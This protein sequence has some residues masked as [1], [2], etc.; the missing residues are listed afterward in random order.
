MHRKKWLLFCVLILSLST[1]SSAWAAS[2]Y[3]FTDSVGKWWEQS[4]AECSAAGLVGGRSSGKFDPKA[5]VSRGEAILF[6]VRALGQRAEADNYNISAGNYN[7]PAGFPEIY[8]RSVA[9]AADKGY[10]SKAGIPSMQPKQPANRA[11]VAVLFANALKLSADGYQLNF[12]DNSAIPSSLQGYVA[13][14]VKH[15]IMS[16]RTGNKFEPNANVTRAEM[17]AIICRLVES[18]KIAPYPDKQFVAKLTAVDAVGRKITVTKGGQTLSYSLQTDALIYKDGTRI[19]LSSFKVNDSAKIVLDSTN[20]VVFMAYSIV[21]PTSGSVGTGNNV[22]I[23]TTYT[24]TIKGL[25]TGSLSF[26]PDSSAINAYPLAGSLK[27]TQGGLT[28][29]LTALTSGARAEIKVTGGSVTEVNLISSLPTGTEKKGYIVNMYL[30]YFTVRYDN[31]TS[32]QIEKNLVTGTFLQYARGQ[33]VALYKSGNFITSI[34][35]LNEASKLFGDIVNVNSSAIAIEDLDD[36][37]RSI[38]LASS[39]RVKDEDGDSMDLDDLEEEDS[40]E[41]EIN[42][43]GDAVIIKLTDGSSSSSSSSNLFGEITDVDTSGDWGITIEQLDGDKETYDVEDDVDVYDED[44]D[45]IDFDELDDGDYVKLKQNSKDD[46]TRIDVFDVDE[47]EGEVYED[48]D[49]SGSWGITIK[50]SGSSKKT[51]EVSKDVEVDEDGKSR[52]FD[53]IED[54]DDVKLVIDNDADEVIAISI[55]DKD[56]NDD[57]TYEGTVTGLD[58]D[59]DEITIKD[60]SSKTYDLARNV[61]VE[62][63]N[64]EIDLDEILIGSEVEVTIDDDEVTEIEITDDE[65]IEIEGEMV[66]VSSSYIKLEQENGEHKLEYASNVKLYDD[67]GKSISKSDLRD[68]EDDDVTIELKDGEIYKLEVQ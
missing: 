32:E 15:G 13:A 11:E 16:G 36:Y 57:D 51:Y 22:S 7:F 4:I 45:D 68:Y 6:L 41:I 1:I 3:L 52:D 48:V 54:G 61:K 47:V 20:K 63:D 62:K 33:R 55:L 8:K 60:G 64:D 35:P 14:A 12:K 17:A 34:V 65:D 5:S 59:D 30:D 66:S 10:I 40:V 43:Q 50:K 56:D 24:G 42:N 9:L 21:G 25:T 31:G 19:S 44:G 39:Y 46:I 18:G 37:E 53:D 23:T 26:Q 29:D 28:K 67:R 58:L 49:T 2:P 38:D 27:I